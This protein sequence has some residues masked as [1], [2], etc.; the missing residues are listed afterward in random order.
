MATRK[1]SD[2]NLTGKKYNDASA[3][4]AK[5]VDIPDLPTLT[6]A[7]NVGTSRAFNNGAATIAVTAA[8]RGGVPA[9][10]TATSNPGAFTATG[11]SPLTVTGLQSATSYTFTAF[12]TTATGN[13]PTT[14]GF[15][16][17]LNLIII[18]L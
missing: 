4:A 12:A 7:V 3:G 6:S 5:I 10:F 14:F 1:A 15:S 2:S 8:A 17:F 13:S 11:S 16:I 9:T 18:G